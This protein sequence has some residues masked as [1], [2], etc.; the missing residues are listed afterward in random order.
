MKLPYFNVKALRNPAFKWQLGT[1]K[2]H[3]I[4]QRATHYTFILFAR[5]SS[6]CRFPS[7]GRKRSHLPD[8]NNDNLWIKSLEDETGDILYSCCRQQMPEKDLKQKNAHL[9]VTLSPRAH[10]F[11]V[12]LKIETV[13]VDVRTS[14]WNVTGDARQ[15][16]EL[17]GSWWPNHY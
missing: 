2:E 13:T 12:T 14:V 7:L 8:V 5:I 11:F 15:K 16:N 17:A 6:W 3:L 9:S 10:S 1:V 4:P